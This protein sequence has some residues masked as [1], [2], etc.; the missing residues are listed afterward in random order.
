MLVDLCFPIQEHWRYSKFHRE[1]LSSKEKGDFWEITGFTMGSHWFSHMDFP[2][3]TGPEYPDSEAFPL[4]AYNGKASV[5][6][7]TRPD[8]KNHGFTVEDMEKATEGRK[9]QKILLLRSDWEKQSDWNTTDFWDNAPFMTPEALEWIVAKKP[10][11]VAF[12]F[13]QD[14]TIR[15]GRFRKVTPDDQ[16][17]H[18]ILLRNNNILL[19]EY[20]HNFDKIGADECEFICLPLKLPHIDG[21]PVRAVAKV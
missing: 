17:S 5:I 12:D 10:T 8:L 2:R 7:L 11:C 1:M 18:T 21:G 14:Y 9:L 20:V 15:E 19:V 16:P 4:E 6:D 13:P 3:H